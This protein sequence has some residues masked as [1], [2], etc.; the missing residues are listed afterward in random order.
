MAVLQGTVPV[1]ELDLCL[2]SVVERS[3][4]RED[5]EAP[6]VEG[7]KCEGT[8]I[9][10]KGQAERASHANTKKRDTK[11]KSFEKSNASCSER[12]RPGVVG[13]CLLVVLGSES[14]VAFVSFTICNEELLLFCER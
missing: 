12:S 7:Q 4:G 9:N 6:A 14:I 10:A 11:R 13:H 5:G 8:V 1:C 2:R 3:C